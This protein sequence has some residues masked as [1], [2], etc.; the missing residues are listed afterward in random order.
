[1]IYAGDPSSLTLSITTDDETP[2]PKDLSGEQWTAQW[3]PETKSSRFIDIDVYT[4][5]AD[6]GIIIL[7]LS[8]NDTRAMKGR[9]VFDLQGSISGTI[10]RGK[11]S[12]QQDVT[13]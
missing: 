12:W 2:L 6:E 9:G 4:S 11:T 13:R 8:P 3:R 5:Q 10:L 7:Y 1:M